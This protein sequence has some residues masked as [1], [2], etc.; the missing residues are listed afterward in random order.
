MLY[1]ASWTSVV[2]GYTPMWA[3]LEFDKA[4]ETLVNEI[5]RN[6][7]RWAFG[8]PTLK[9]QYEQAIKTIQEAPEGNLK[10]QLRWHIFRIYEDYS[11]AECVKRA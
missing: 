10:I 5:S 11:P 6:L 8:D 9:E 2:N 1:K 3:E 4:K 7:G